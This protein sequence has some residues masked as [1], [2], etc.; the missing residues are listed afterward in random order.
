M[1]TSA[2]EDKAAI[3]ELIVGLADSAQATIATTLREFDAP[4]SVALPLRILALSEEPVTPRELARRLGRDPSTASLTADKLEAAG[5]IARRPHPDDGRKRVLVLT[6]RGRQLWS[7]MRD[8]LHESAVFE[9]LTRP[10][11]RQLLDLLTRM[12]G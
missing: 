12:R 5:L 10:E 3:L 11:Q 9:R 4:A 6:D 1:G 8:R 7:D 2:S